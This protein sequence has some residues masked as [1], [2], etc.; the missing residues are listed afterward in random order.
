RAVAPPGR[1]AAELVESSR[2][3]REL[4]AMLR[5]RR[6]T[7]VLVVTRAASVPRVETER[8]LR[9]LRRLE[10]AVAAVVVNARTLTTGACRRCRAAAAGERREVTAL[11]R[12]TK[13]AI[14][15]ARL[16]A[17]PPRGP[18]HLHRW[19]RTWIGRER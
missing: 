17:P 8:L 7:R 16:V 3:V 15:Q 12:S 2:S 18:S 19:A 13:S 4:Q 10:V 5:D 6:K 11:R 1:L 14:I 9:Q